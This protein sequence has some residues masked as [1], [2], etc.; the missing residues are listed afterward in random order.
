[1]NKLPP[2]LPQPEEMS[3][4]GG[5]IAVGS[6][7]RLRAIPGDAA[8]RRIALE[9]A[10]EIARITGGP[11][12]RS[13][14][15]EGEAG[16]ETGAALT[17]VTDRGEG[18]LGDE[19][20]RLSV[21]PREIRLIGA[22]PAG[23]FYGSRTLLQLLPLG[24]AADAALPCLEILDRPRFAWRGL[25]LDVSRHFFPAERIH[26]LIESLALHKLNRFHWHLTDDQGWR[27][28]IPRHPRLA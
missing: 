1:M 12:L 10:R 24:P 22:T 20:Y 8:T 2:L 7:T 13:T 15:A 25:H 6:L 9:I 27:I 18:T 5:E 11:P 17:L 28:E 23:L 14:G 19:G 21:G 4:S 16:S 26:Q 3:L